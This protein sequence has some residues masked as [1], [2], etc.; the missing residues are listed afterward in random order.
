MPFSISS[1]H[2]GSFNGNAFTAE[3]WRMRHGKSMR[4]AQQN[5]T[6]GTGTLQFVTQ[7]HSL[8]LS[9]DGQ[10]VA[11]ATDHALAKG[12]IGVR[13]VSGAAVDDYQA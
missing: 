3:I 2:A 9:L 5:V 4:L 11:S 6:S 8:T 12:G 10:V 7:G 13:S 1:K